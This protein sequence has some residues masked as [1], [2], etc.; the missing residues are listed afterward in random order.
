MRRTGYAVVLVLLAIAMLAGLLQLPPPGSAESPVQ[1]HAT[2]EYAAAAAERGGVTNLVTAV[3]LDY[4]ALDTFGEVSVIFAALIAVLT[5][6]GASRR[7]PKPD[8]R[9]G[10]SLPPSPVVDYVVRLLAPF[11]AAFAAFVMISGD[12]LPGGGFQGGVVLGAMTI[13]LSV[14]MGR[15]RVEGLLRR[16]AR[17][18][19]RAVA[20]LSFV[21]LALFGL[22]ATG[23]W[24]GLPDS[25]PV[26]H[27]LLVLLDIAIGVGGAAVLAGIFL[28]LARE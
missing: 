14:A 28:A 18:W 7:S 12:V 24:F 15:E 8:V 1:R 10:G 25:T 20:P 9:P 3:L 11:M 21:L 23:W 4:R 6:A 16:G 19:V 22:A 13:L 26:R 17:F 27:A 5:V 2:A